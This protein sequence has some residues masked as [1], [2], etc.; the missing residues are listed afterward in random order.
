MGNFKFITLNVGRNKSLPGLRKIFENKKVDVCFLQESI[1]SLDEL[2]SFTLGW[3]V[4]VAV[5]YNG[6][7]GLA[8]MWR[9]YLPVV[10]VTNIVEGRA[11]VASL[12][13]YTLL[14]IYAPAG[15]NKK[16][17]REAFFGRE[18]FRFFRSRPLDSFIFGGDFNSVLKKVDIRGGV[19]YLYK[20]SNALSNLVAFGEL[21]DALRFWNPGARVF[22]F[23]RP[24]MAF[25]R[26]D[27]F[28]LSKDLLN[29]IVGVE[30]FS[31]LSDHCVVFMEL[32]LDLDNPR[33][34][35]QLR[36]TYW[37][38]NNAI[39][40]DKAFVDSFSRFWKDCV[41]MKDDFVSVDE[42]WDVCAKPE[43]KLFV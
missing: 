42:W 8:L 30:H 18:I 15:S 20:K 14:N 22:T 35:R 4:D 25:S 37:K 29:N 31:S 21:G 38:L 11:M 19:G 3:G 23:F 24:G 17:E 33:P 36:K 32:D 10:G 28:Y 5:N 1:L 2:K 41:G 12:G 9:S 27:R 6:K 13:D 40:K 7:F 16:G 43:L 34:R 39:V 26:L